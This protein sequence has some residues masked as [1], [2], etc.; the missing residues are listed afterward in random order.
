M[1]FSA[2]T[3]TKTEPHSVPLHLLHHA[4]QSLGNLTTGRNGNSIKTYDGNFWECYAKGAKPGMMYKY[5]I[6]RQDGNCVEH[7]DPY[8]FG[9]ELRPNFASIIRDLSHYKFKDSKWMQKRSVCKDKPLNI[10][11]LHFGS[12]KKPSEKA[13]DWYTYVE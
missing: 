2:H 9:M 5:R 1:N 4:L 12:F 6:Y 10:Y 8:G 7:C 11:E 13:D 3:R